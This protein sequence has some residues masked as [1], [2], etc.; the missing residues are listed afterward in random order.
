MTRKI[1][2]LT[3]TRADYGIFHS[4]LKE[5]EKTDGLELS[6]LVCGMH[7]SEDF[8]MTINEIKKDGFK[9]EESF[10]TIVAG[11]TGASMAKGVALTM[12]NVAQSLNRINPDVLLL[13]GDRGEM[14]GAASAAAF[15]NIPVAHIH[16]GE[17]TG[18]IDESIRHAITK[19]SHV[20]FPANED[21]ADRIKKLGEREKNI[22]TV[23]G[24][25]LDYIANAKLIE[26]KEFLQKFELE[27]NKVLL[28]TQH[29]VTT[30]RDKVEEQIRATMEAIIELGYQTVITYPNSDNGGKIIIEV[31]DEY[32]KKYPQLRVFKNLS[33][34]E[35][36]SLL[37]VA[38]AMVG[39]SSSGIIEAPSFKLPV[40]NIGTRQNGRLRATNVI[41]VDYGK[42]NVINGIKKAIF[43]EN[44]KKELES[45]VNP[46]G[47]G[48]A[49][50]RIA[51]ILKN[52][53]INREL[54]Q[55]RITY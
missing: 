21:A 12:M 16:G 25:G 2:V 23:G 28:L 34:I 10:E 20:H 30:E 52:M 7:L 39:N 19:L 45:C 32:R 17:V 13:L 24:P 27:D 49:G 35:Y 54:I 41:D 46:Y 15:M 11:D 29:P 37:D 1:C 18:T 47:D 51:K 55:K 42:D 43:D 53:D 48:K 5:I 6:L 22:F 44:F 26:R 38:D 36:L 4:V 50:K 14:L 31:I 3:G 9:V 40:V 33:Q 8:G